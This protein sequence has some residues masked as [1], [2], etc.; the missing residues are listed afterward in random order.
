MD[1]ITRKSVGRPRKTLADV[2]FGKQAG[3]DVENDVRQRETGEAGLGAQA[4]D[5]A[6]VAGR[7]EVINKQRREMQNRVNQLNMALANR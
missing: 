4:D 1:Q 2:I 5:A 6:E 3:S 7:L